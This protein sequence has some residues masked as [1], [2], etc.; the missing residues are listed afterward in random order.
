ME[1]I[2]KIALL[3]LCSPLIILVA[4]LAVLF[5]IF[6]FEWF[7]AF[8]CVAAA[9]GIFYNKATKK[10]KDEVTKKPLDKQ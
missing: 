3:I 10:R 8:A 2:G 4:I 5:V 6:N 7:V 1:S 9:Y